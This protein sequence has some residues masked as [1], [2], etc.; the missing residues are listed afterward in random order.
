MLKTCVLIATHIPNI[1]KMYVGESLLQRIKLNLPAAD[2]IVGINPSDVQNE[3][4]S[5]VKQYTD[6]WELTPQHLVINSDASAYQTALRI[7][8]KNLKNYD[9]VWFLHTLGTSTGYDDIRELHLKNLLDDKDNFIFAKDHRYIGGYCSWLSPAP[10]LYMDTIYDTVINRFGQFN[11]TNF[12]Y[13]A[14]GTMYVLKG[15]VLNKILLNVN[16]S[17]LNELLW[18]HSIDTGDKFFFERDF[19]TAVYKSG[20]VLI[21]ICYTNAYQW[22]VENIKDFYKQ[23][24]NNWLIV[25]NLEKDILTII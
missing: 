20:Y 7:Y 25:N 2:L 21:P 12:R 16:D 14:G 9:F 10:Y 4:I 23:N 17:L 13:L 8:N 6:L 1:D 24:L 22:Q 19:I 18:V 5:I 11:Y 15:S 3:W